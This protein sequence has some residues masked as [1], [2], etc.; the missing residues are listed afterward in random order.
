MK[1][2]FEWQL[3]HRRHTNHRCIRLMTV[4]IFLSNYDPKLIDKQERMFYNETW[5]NWIFAASVPSKTPQINPENRENGVRTNYP[6]TPYT[7][8]SRLGGCIKTPQI[9]GENGENGVRSINVLNPYTPAAPT[10]PL[11]PKL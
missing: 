2:Q 4:R 8:K 9:N 11:P 6:L 3:T 7:Q 5:R 10:Q 1:S